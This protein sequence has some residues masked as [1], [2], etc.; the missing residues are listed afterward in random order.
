MVDNLGEK[1]EP[2]ECKDIV[3]HPNKKNRQHNAIMHQLIMISEGLNHE[4]Y[5][6]NEN[7]NEWDV[8]KV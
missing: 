1:L 7:S 3:L 4:Q 8:G 6:M 2:M 5:E